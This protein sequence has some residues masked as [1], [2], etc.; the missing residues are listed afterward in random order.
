MKIL[1]NLKRN[2]INRVAVLHKGIE[3]IYIYN[4]NDE[5]ISLL[6]GV[7]LV[8]EYKKI[9]DTGFQACIECEMANKIT[10][11][12][13][14]DLNETIEF[15]IKIHEA[16]KIIRKINEKLKTSFPSF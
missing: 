9:F 4:Q 16:N 2:N 3:Y 14:K 8:S 11:G 15:D 6:T 10:K 13:S 7:D 5:M 12:I 1:Y